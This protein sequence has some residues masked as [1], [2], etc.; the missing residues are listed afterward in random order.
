M[1]RISYPAIPFLLLAFAVMA[2]FSFS[3]PVPPPEELGTW[4][5]DSGV[6]RGL[7]LRD[8]QIKQIEQAFLNH[9]S[10]LNNLTNE[11]QHQ[12]SILQSVIDTS[13][14]DEKKATAQ[15][16][17]VVTARARLEKER[18]MMA[19]DIRRAVSYDQWKK[20]QEMQRAQ[21]NAAP[22]PAAIP[23]KATPKAESGA[24]GS[25]EVIYQ[26]GGPVSD[27]VPIQR[28]NPG[29]TPQAKDKKVEGSILLA[30]VIGKDGVVRNV[31]VLRGLGYGLDE[32]A[33]DT[34]TKRWLFKPSLLNGQPV[35]VQAMI[36]VT[37]HFYQ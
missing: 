35:T 36:E 20:L 21:T 14:L 26:V 29:F 9:R 25:E 6:V 16:D 5:R 13:S 34:V 32:S 12:E 28:P 19:L 30:V 2:Q 4:W 11:L 18:T 37:F 33:V 7:Q 15:I 22:A 27:P 10:E 8:S 31:K 17:Q 1:K 23:N 24:S 3:S